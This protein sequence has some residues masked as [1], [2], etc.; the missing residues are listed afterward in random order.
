MGF[1]SCNDITDMI[2][3]TSAYPQ[4]LGAYFVVLGDG[5]SKC[6]LYEKRELASKI[7]SSIF[8]MTAES[9]CDNTE[10]EAL[11]STL[12]AFA[13]DYGTCKTKRPLAD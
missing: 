10:A 6:C 4:D 11:P 7:I 13:L 2:P 3:P 8:V 9:V 12:L 1:G 5:V